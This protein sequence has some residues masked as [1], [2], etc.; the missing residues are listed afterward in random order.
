LQSRVEPCVFGGAPD[1]AQCGCAIS[2]GLHW[3]RTVKVAGPVKVDHFMQGSMDIGRFV[4]RLR[5]RPV[6]PA[7]WNAPVT[8]LAQAAELVQI[9]ARDDAVTG[10]AESSDTSPESD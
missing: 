5:A 3:V 8:P 9:G 1:C 10:S 2:S 4:N 6:E 7:R